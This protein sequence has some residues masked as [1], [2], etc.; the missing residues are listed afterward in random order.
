M[1]L[2]WLNALRESEENID[3]PEDILEDVID[4]LEHQSAQNIKA[5]QVGIEYD[6]QV[7]CD[8]CRR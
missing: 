1:D 7:I 2:S 8:V 6:D 4:Q 3:I 5:K